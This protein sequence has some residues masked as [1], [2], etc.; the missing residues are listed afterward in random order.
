MVVGELLVA[1]GNAKL[2]QPS[3]E[4]AGTVKQIEL[5]LL[6]AINV[7]RLLPAEIFRLPFDRNDRVLSHPIRPAL[8]DDLACVKGHRQSNTEKL[9]RIGIVAR[10]HRQRVDH[11]AGT[12]RV[13][14]GCLEL[15]PSLL[16]GVLGTGKGP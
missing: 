7:E 6:A 1:M 2:V 8:F 13:L 16:D 5:V 9:R 10:R 12:L 15:L 4:P 14:F 3:H 11:L